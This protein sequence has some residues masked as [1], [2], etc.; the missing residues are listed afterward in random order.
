M[1][2]PYK[3][4]PVLGLELICYANTVCFCFATFYVSKVEKSQDV[5]AYI[6]GTISLVL[7]LI[8]LSYHVITQLFF[9]IRLG[10]TLKNKLAQR[11]SDAKTEEQINLV[12]QDKKN[13]EPVTFSVVDP[14][15]RGE[16]EPQ[17]HPADIPRN[18]RNTT[19]NVSESTGHEENELKPFEQKV[20]D[21]STPYILMK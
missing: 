7:F 1:F 3:S 11:F 17:P 8:V 2:R 18:R 19:K 16:E 21:S 10:K 12:V 4:W 9:A 5:I 20:A 6:S 15:T 14:P 13:D